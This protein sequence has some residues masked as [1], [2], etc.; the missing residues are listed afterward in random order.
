MMLS[1]MDTPIMAVGRGDRLLNT[2]HRHGEGGEEFTYQTLNER[3]GNK[4]HN[5]AQ[6]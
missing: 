1:G 2:E 5:G 6:C 4:H 3:Q